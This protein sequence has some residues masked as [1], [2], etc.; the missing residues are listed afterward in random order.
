MAASGIHPPFAAD[1]KWLEVLVLCGFLEKTIGERF[2]TIPPRQ[3]ASCKAWKNDRGTF[4]N[5]TRNDTLKQQQTGD[6]IRGIVKRYPNDTPTI[7][8]LTPPSHYS[9]TC[10]CTGPL[11]HRC[12]QHTQRTHRARY[13]INWPCLSPSGCAAGCARKRYLW[14]G[15]DTPRLAAT[16]SHFWDLLKFPDLAICIYNI[17][18]LIFEYV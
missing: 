12:T 17:T 5:D 9:K 14:A 13:P 6:S 16:S 10:H 18:I 4:Q 15:N 8:P 2:K 1:E 7:P 3:W 11:Q